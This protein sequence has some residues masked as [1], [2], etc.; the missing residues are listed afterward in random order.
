MQ[1]ILVFV[2]AQST[3]INL[4]WSIVNSL[5]L[6]TGG[7]GFDLVLERENFVFTACILGFRGPTSY[8]YKGCQESFSGVK[9]LVKFAIYIL[10]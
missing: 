7:S 9:W 4:E 8:V 6:T 3:R 10:I 1:F 2:S 5:G